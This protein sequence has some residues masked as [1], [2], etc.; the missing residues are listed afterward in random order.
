MT[1]SFFIKLFHPIAVL[2]QAFRQ[3]FTRPDTLLLGRSN[4]SDVTAIKP[5]QEYLTAPFAAPSP[6]VPVPPVPDWGPL[7][8][9]KFGCCVYSATGH[10]EQAAQIVLGGKVL[11]VNTLAT[12][13]LSGLWGYKWYM[14][15]YDGGKDQ[16][17]EWVVVL[18][19]WRLAKIGAG[20]AGN[21]VRINWTDPTEV[22]QVIENL[23]VVL[24]GAQLPETYDAQFNA[25][26]TPVWSLTGTAADNTDAGGHALAIVAYDA[27]YWYAI[28][29]GVVVRIERAWFAKYVDEA[30]SVILPELI[31]S[32]KYN[33][34]DLATLEADQ[35][36]LVA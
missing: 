17:C 4:K 13:L 5:I 12:E 26:A 9:E 28:S 19:K 10:A 27:T 3:H 33:N 6:S 14:K 29:W 31:T 32:G 36:Q 7:N 24:V 34:I 16:G 15:A 25:S 22:E 30:Y 2:R 21:W 8:N 35:A 20:K 18:N 11:N 23:G 1:N